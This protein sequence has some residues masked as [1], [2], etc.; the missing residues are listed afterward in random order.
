MAQSHSGET[1]IRSDVTRMEHENS[2]PYSQRPVRGPVLE[3]AAFS[4]IAFTI[5]LKIPLQYYCPVH[6]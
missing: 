5:F 3:A 6:T 2:K 4:L 1:Y